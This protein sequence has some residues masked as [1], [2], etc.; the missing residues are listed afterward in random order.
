MMNWL[1]FAACSSKTGFLAGYSAAHTS[2]VQEGHFKSL[3]PSL[4]VEYNLRAGNLENVYY[5]YW[6][7]NATDFRSSLKEVRLVL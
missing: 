3:K 4:V 2:Q 7:E 1:C 5:L 6:M